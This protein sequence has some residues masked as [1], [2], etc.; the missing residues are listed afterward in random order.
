M[1]LRDRSEAVRRDLKHD[2]DLLD[3]ISVDSF[4]DSDSIAYLRRK[5]QTQYE[6]EREMQRNI[7]VM[8]ESEAKHN[9]EKQENKWNDDASIREQQL[10]VLLDERLSDI[11]VKMIECIER[12]N[13]LISI[14]ENHI[15]AIEGTNDRLKE[16]MGEK[17]EERFMPPR[18]LT[19]I[20]QNSPK[21][22]PTSARPASSSTFN[23]IFPNLDYD[24]KDLKLTDNRPGS[25]STENSELSGC[26]RYGR[27]KIA[28]C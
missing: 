19:Q 27:K 28:W 1:L 4:D 18:P 12:Q 16:L 13:D 17:S 2:L 5:F 25:C 8:Y 11:E 24:F 10:K 20:S 7:E 3:R 14:R 26:P 22:R 21:F 15:K 9:L 23:T 6:C